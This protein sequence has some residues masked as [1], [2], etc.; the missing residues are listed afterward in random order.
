MQVGT[1][2]YF[3]ELS[4][5]NPYIGGQFD[6]QFLLGK[7]ALR[8]MWNKSWAVNTTGTY[9]VTHTFVPLLLKSSDPRLIFM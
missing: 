3:L 7:M 8:E 2:E 9:I 4:M 6:Q 1:T 5:A